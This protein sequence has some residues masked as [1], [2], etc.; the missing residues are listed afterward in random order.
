MILSFLEIRPKQ[1]LGTRAKN[2]I[3]LTGT[4]ALWFISQQLGVKRV[5]QGGFN[6]STRRRVAKRCCGVEKSLSL[7][8]FGCRVHHVH[9]G[10]HQSLFSLA[11]C[12]WPRCACI[13]AIILGPGAEAKKPTGAV[14]SFSLGNDVI[15]CSCGRVRLPFAVFSLLRP[16]KTSLI[17][18]R[19][20]PMCYWPDSLQKRFQAKRTIFST[21]RAH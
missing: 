21:A 14:R 5:S 7:R 19:H 6:I 17:A 12:R 15:W 3:R 2:N 11:M 8:R 13:I 18:P 1:K 16:N 20:M 9:L 10:M 4:S